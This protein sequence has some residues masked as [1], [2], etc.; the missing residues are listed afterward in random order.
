MYTIKYYSAVKKEWNPVVCNDMDGPPGHY[1]KWNHSHEDKYHMISYMCNLKKKKKK[2]NL[3]A[4]E[5]KSVTAR[6]S[7][8][9]VVEINKVFLNKLI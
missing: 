5:E 8:F 1:A 4:T 3:I 9:W 6:G 2:T 7:V